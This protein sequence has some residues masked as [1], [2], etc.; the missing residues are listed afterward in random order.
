MNIIILG[1]PGSGKGT[2]CE[3][4]VK[5]FDYQLICA[6]DILRNE[7]SSG[8]VLGNKIAEIID[9]GNLVPDQLIT[10]LIFKEFEKPIRLGR[11]YLIDGYPR[12]EKQA[13]DLDSM[14]NVPIVLWL[15]VSDETT[16]KRNLK[17]GLTSGRPDD[18]NE[19]I[20]KQRLENYKKQSLPL[21][22]F[23]SDMIVEIDGEG[24]IEEVYKRV[25]DTLFEDVKEMKDIEDIL[26]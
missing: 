14:I 20:I 25:V 6:G 18:A 21:K 23:Y 5:D 16:I 2:V 8:S 7:K 19:E 12:T 17:R 15:E 3:R 11:S 1:P 26:E 10:S 4:L 24:T 9:K 13:M 22:S